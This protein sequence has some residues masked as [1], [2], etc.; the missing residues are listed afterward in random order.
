MKHENKK[1]ISGIDVGT[2][3]IA[4]IIAETNNDSI[5]ILGFGESN[6]EGL[7]RGIVVDVEK[8]SNAIEEAITKAEEQADYEVNSAFIGITGEHVKGINCSGT[9]TISNNEYSFIDEYNEKLS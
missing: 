1:I 9:I 8:T 2:T 6:S 4:V 3:K 5:N 7:H